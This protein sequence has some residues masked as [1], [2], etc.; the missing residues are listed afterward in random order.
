[1]ADKPKTLILC[2][3]QDNDIGKKAGV[4]TPIVGKDGIIQ[5]ATALAICDPEEADSNAMFGAVKILNQMVEKYPAEEFQIATIAGSQSG[6]IEADRKIVVE[7]GEVLGQYPAT[8]IVLVTDGFADD[9]LLPILQSRVPITSVQHVVVKHSERI[10]ET[11]I[12]F[13]K[14]LRMLIDDPY[15]SRIA[16]GVPG[17][18][19]IIFGFLTALNQLQNAGLAVT[20]VLGIV[21]FAKGFGFYDRLVLYRPRLPHPEQQLIFASRLVGSVLVF[22]GAYQGIDGIAVALPP[23]VQPLIDISW[24]AG[25]VPSLLA[26]FIIKGVDMITVGIMVAIIGSGVNY[27]LHKDERFTNNIVSSIMAF[28]MW[29]IALASAEVLLN[30]KMKITL[31]SPLVIYT[32]LSIATTI[33]AVAAIYRRYKRLPFT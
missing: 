15:Y 12:V 7:L 31:T 32:F 10:E 24:W 23:V 17:V 13:F 29:L 27:Y 5:A 16:L 9:I 11:Y 22:V 20:F 30:P 33:I 8:G 26:A 2:V 28:W 18:L 25:Q 4:A 1:M 21:F 6:S 19:L 14:Y 3:D